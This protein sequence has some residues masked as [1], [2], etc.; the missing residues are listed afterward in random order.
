MPPR[1]RNA[2][3]HYVPQFYLRQWSQDGEH[4]WAYPKTA[5]NPIGTTI[6]NVACE[7]G[8][9]STP[10]A[11]PEASFSS[12]EEDLSQ[13]ESIHAK[14]WPGI[15]DRAANSETRRNLATFLALLFLRHPT[16]KSDIERIRDEIREAVSHL[17]PETQIEVS[18]KERT[19]EFS[20]GEILRH[21]DANQTAI[22]SAF[23][24]CMHS[25]LDV[26]ANALF[27]RP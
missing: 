3:H 21:T 25:N 14:V 6:A 15:F 9:H 12:E 24:D 19:G 10:T 20:V 5:H 2:R 27:D 7:S 13:I 17:S 16:R 8:L 18:I 4:I 23:I 11:Q 1:K 22:S 26:V